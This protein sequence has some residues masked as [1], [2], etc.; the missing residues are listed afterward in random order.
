MEEW[1]LDFEWLKIRHFIKKRFGR[2]QLP[3]LN[4]I[5]FII[6]IQELGRW[7]NQ[8]TKEEK[9]DLMHIAVCRLLS[10]QSYYTFE[11]RDADGWPHWKLLKPIKAQGMDDQEALLKENV[12]RY[13]KEWEAENG[14][15]E[16]E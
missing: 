5:L 15:L 12:I 11:G 13:F 2:D 9:Q 14:P 16:E 7:Q 1:E 8:F 10:Y 6:G 4:A 3:D